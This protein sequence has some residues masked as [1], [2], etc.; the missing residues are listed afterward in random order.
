M[1]KLLQLKNQL[2]ARMPKF[3]RQA[4]HKKLKLRNTSWRRPRGSDS[5]QKIRKRSYPARVSIGY[6]TPKKLRNLL[7]NGL[8]E[9]V[10]ANVMHL[11]KLDKKR[12]GVVLA[13]TLS[14]RK[15]V[16]VLKECLNQGLTVI[17]I[18]NPDEYIKSYEVKIKEKQESKKKKPKKAEPK[19]VKKAP[20]PQ[21]KQKKEE[22]SPEEARI[23]EKKEKDKLLIKKR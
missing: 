17:N 6:R 8:K 23:K 1:E 4:M 7:S 15:K 12:E 5:K 20:S 19:E 3:R 14:R 9:V 22:L 10:I 16:E 21:S 13:R 2:K 18:K 11:K